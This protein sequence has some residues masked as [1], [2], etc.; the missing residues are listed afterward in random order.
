MP[1]VPRV[2]PIDRRMERF[3]REPV[4]VR[5]AASVIVGTTFLLV[6]ASGVA[7]R[8]L[9]HRAYSTIWLGMWWALQTVTTVGYGYVTPRILWAGSWVRL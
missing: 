3:L 1:S 8:V 6:V 4:S 7:M 5:N 2:N 9:D